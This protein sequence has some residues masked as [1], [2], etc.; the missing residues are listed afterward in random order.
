MWP[1]SFSLCVSVCLSLSLSLS[2]EHWVSQINTWHL[3]NS[4][5]T[6][7]SLSLL[8]SVHI[9]SLTLYHHE[10]WGLKTCWMYPSSELFTHEGAWWQLS[11]WFICPVL[12]P[13]H[14]SLFFFLKGQPNLRSI[15]GMEDK[16][17]TAVFH[18]N[19]HPLC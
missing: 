3:H 14:F 4:Y 13:S 7:F 12:C 11:R 2:E 16:L 17:S 15:K 19:S 5:V 6:Q 1:S 18:S 8:L 9:C 10:K